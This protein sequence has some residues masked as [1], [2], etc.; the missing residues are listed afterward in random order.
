MAKKYDVSRF[1][2]FYVSRLYNSTKF[3][4]QCTPK[5]LINVLGSV[6]D[7]GNYQPPIELQ[8]MSG[9]IKQ[10]KISFKKLKGYATSNYGGKLTAKGKKFARVYLSTIIK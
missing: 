2:T 5:E 7:E 8:F 4:V 6:M 10:E 3:L 1:R 9:K